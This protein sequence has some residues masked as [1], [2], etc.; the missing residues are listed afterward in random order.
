MDRKDCL[1]E[2]LNIT[3]KGR[4]AFYSS[5]ENSFK[6]I[7]EFWSSYLNRDIKPHDVG[8]MMCLLK[9]ARI[10]TGKYK[11]DNYVDIAGYSACACELQHFDDLDNKYSN[12]KKLDRDSECDNCSLNDLCWGELYE[13]KGSKD[14]EVY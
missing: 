14:E 4:E 13:E 6:L 9:I 10:S 2:A 1:N 5:P 11:A 3:C 8:V 7:A 12:C